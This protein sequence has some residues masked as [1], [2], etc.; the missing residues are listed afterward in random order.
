MNS[1]IMNFDDSTDIN[2]AYIELKKLYPKVEIIKQKHQKI[3]EN[4]YEVR[5]ELLDTHTPD[6]KPKRQ[7]TQEEYHQF[8]EETYG[9]I[10]DPTFVEPPEIEYESPREII[11]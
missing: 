1:L 2:A 8:L 3:S 6:G 5:N 4:I 11:V 9:S 10:D 7:M